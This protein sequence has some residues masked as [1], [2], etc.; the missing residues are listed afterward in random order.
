MKR[1]LTTIM[2]VAFAS[3][4]WAIDF[5]SVGSIDVCHDVAILDADATDGSGKAGI[6]YTAITCKYK[7]GNQAS[8]T[9]MTL[10]D[11]TAG[12]QLDN[13]FKE[14]ANGVYQICP[15]DAA[16]ASGR[17][18]TIW[19]YGATD[20]APMWLRVVLTDATPNVNVVSASDTAEYTTVP[21]TGSEDL[22]TMVRVLY[23]MAVAKFDSTASEQTWYQS[24]G[25]S[26][27][28]TKDITDNG[29][30]YSRT[31]QEAND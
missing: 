29:T 10:V 4:A 15:P 19:C 6:A 9:T 18:T 22:L 1:L 7:R 25:S 3:P 30:T 20:A 31:A 23:Q 5:V 14:V 28:T 21:T 2:L 17:Y 13:S 24:N 16:Y 26:V 11:G 12:T 8:P 27:W